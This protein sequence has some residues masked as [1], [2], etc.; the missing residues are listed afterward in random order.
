M[1]S[2]RSPGA[3]EPGATAAGMENARSPVGTNADSGPT[4]V[5][6]KPGAREDLAVRD[7]GDQDAIG[8][9]AR[10]WS[11]TPAAPSDEGTVVPTTSSVSRMVP[12]VSGPAAT[13]TDAGG[14]TSGRVDRSRWA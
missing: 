11:T 5:R 9:L 8:G 13:T 10:A 7:V 3:S 14:P 1:T 4:P 6:P 2:M 12:R